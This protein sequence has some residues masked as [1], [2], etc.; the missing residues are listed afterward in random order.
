MDS[1]FANI[2]V[3]PFVLEKSR[4][5][6]M[7]DFQN[8][9]IPEKKYMKL[10]ISLALK[11]GGYTHPN[12]LV[13]AVIVKDGKIIG[14]GFHTKFGELHAEREALKSLSEPAIGATMYVTLEPCCHYGKTPPCTEAIIENQLSRVVIGSRDPNPIVAGK[15]AKALRD[16]GIEVIEDFMRDECDAINK[17]FLH[18][19]RNKRPYVTLKYAMTID[20][21]IA[22]F[23]GKSKWITSEEARKHTHLNRGKNMAIMV[24][25]GTV[26]SDN[27]SLTCR[28]GDGLNPVRII[29][30]TNLK[31]PLDAEV[32]TSC[33]ELKENDR[34]P[35]TIVA[36]ASSDAQKISSLKSLGIEVLN[37]N[38]DESG[39]LNLR[40]LM[41]KIG[42]LGIDSLILEG[43]GTLAW[44]AVQSGI[45]DK[46]QAYV[47][48]KIFGGASAKSPVEGKGFMN[49]D[50]ALKL[51][52]TYISQID[53]DFLLEG[54]VI[55][56]SQ[57]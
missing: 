8:K 15:G 47:A 56:C 22:T 54:E 48:P 18:Y 12:P 20:G 42:E 26:L 50:M 35:R 52:N 1:R 13:G 14:Q 51:E 33:S 4:I 36:T 25:I 24:G 43:G 46:V 40:S 37:V 2:P 53:D 3:V 16:S 39:Y 27:P 29:C 32:V 23:S 10:A 41:N 55:N 9:F 17:I 19:I 5:E 21:K 45:V 7:N 11:A 30:D 38:K 57:E 49:P 31:V 34:L 44:S 6:T 28:Y